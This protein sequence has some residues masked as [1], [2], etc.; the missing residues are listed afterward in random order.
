MRRE[1]VLTKRAINEMMTI[2]TFQLK[3]PLEAE[4]RACPPRI[5]LRIRK[6]MNVT[7]LAHAVGYAK[8]EMSIYSSL[9]G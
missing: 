9:Y 1:H 3:L 6:P 4:A 5:T 2:P 7:T 8:G